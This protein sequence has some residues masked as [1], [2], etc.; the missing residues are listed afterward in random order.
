MFKKYFSLI[1]SVLC[2]V[3]MLLNSQC[4]S[5]DDPSNPDCPNYDPCYGKKPANADFAIK[6][7]VGYYTPVF[8]TKEPCDTALQSNYVFFFPTDTLADSYEWRVG[9]DPRVFTS[10]VLYLEFD[11]LGEIEVTL[12][13]KY[14]LNRDCSFYKDSVAIKTKK[15]TVLPRPQART[16]GI[17]N[18]YFTSKPQD[19]FNLETGIDIN[20]SPI[21][22][23][24]NFPNGCVGQQLSEYVNFGY[25]TIEHTNRSLHPGIVSPCAAP[26][27]V[28]YLDFSNRLVLYVLR[29]DIIKKQLVRD[30]FIAQKIR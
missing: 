22:Y 27:I 7:S 20:H 14:N 25:R 6:E 26:N 5:C 9:S 4:R 29:N 8:P 18:G 12:K 10:K 16:I 2:V 11:V 3:A 17:F 1:I 21:Q 13:V 23:Y 24:N 30:T 28:G 15:L 19:T